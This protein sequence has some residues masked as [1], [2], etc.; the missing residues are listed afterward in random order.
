VRL[1]SVATHRRLG[2]PI[3]T[4]APVDAPVLSMAFSP[5]GQILAT[6]GSENGQIRLRNVRTHRQIGR[7][8]SAG[9]FDAYGVVFSPDGNILAATQLGGPAQQWDLRTGKGA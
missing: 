8:M 6:A 4:L 3:G 2:K 9:R 1:W 5:R 7:T